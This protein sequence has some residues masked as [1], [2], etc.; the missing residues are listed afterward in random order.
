MSVQAQTNI[1]TVPFIRD[2]VAYVKD[3]EV[4]VQDGARSGDMVAYTLMAQNPSTLKWEPFD[5]ETATTGLQW[6]RGILMATYT[7]AAIQAADIP[8]VPIIV[9]GKGLVIDEGQ[10]V[11]ENSKTLATVINIPANTNK[12]VETVL[13]EIGIFVQVTQDVDAYQNA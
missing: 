6:P 5:D 3:N 7:E 1:T 8:D 4:L 12:T 13:R 10:L 2:G 9:G 11:I